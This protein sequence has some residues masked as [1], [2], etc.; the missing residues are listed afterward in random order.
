MHIPVATRATYIVVAFIA[1]LVCVLTISVSVCA[2][3]S[4]KNMIMLSSENHGVWSGCVVGEAVVVRG[5]Y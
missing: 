4:G 2:V 3:L 1:M 5:K